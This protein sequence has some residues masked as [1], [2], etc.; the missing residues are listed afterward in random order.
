[1]AAADPDDIGR[2]VTRDMLRIV[3]AYRR[4]VIG[5]ILSAPD[6]LGASLRLLL[7]EVDAIIGRFGR[8]LS[9]AMTQGVM[10]AANAGDE[11]VLDVLRA[12]SVEVPLTMF[13]VSEQLV[14]TLSEYSASLITQIP[15]EARAAIATQVRLAA[16]GGIPTTTLIDRI[17]RN[18]TKPSVFGTIA[19]RAE[20]IARTEVS[21]ARSMAYAEQ[22]AEVAGRFTGTLK[23]WEHANTSPGFTTHQRMNSRPNHMAL[24]RE[25]NARPIPFDAAFDLGGGVTAQY[26]HDPTLPASEAVQCRCRLRLVMP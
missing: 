17:G 16:M 2:A 15:T 18:L 19:R 13:G 11:A 22:G 26:P 14:R 1:M 7:A 20:A 12:A 6:P 4:E 9:G 5:M 8:E 25:T 10:T 23:V 21:R 24:S 3:E